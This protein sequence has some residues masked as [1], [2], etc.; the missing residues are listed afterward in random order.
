[1]ADIL[2]TGGRGLVGRRL[3]NALLNKG[4]QVRHVSRSAEK[5]SKT[6]AFQWDIKTGYIDPAS[7]DGIDHIVHLAGAPIVEKKWTKGRVQELI[8]SRAKSARILFQEV[9]KQ[10]V[11]LKGF[12]SASGSNYYGILDSDRIFSEEDEV[13]NDTIAGITEEWERAVRQFET[14]TRTIR[15]RMGM[16]LSKDGGALPKFANTIKMGIGSP[17]G[18]GKQWVPWV[19][20]DDV[21]AL[22]IHSIEDEEFIGAYNAI[23]DEHITNKQL[24]EGIAKAMKRPVWVPKLPAFILRLMLGERADL[25]LKGYRLSNRKLKDAG[26]KFQF[27]TLEQALS[28][29]FN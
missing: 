4:H 11:E 9:Q 14:L 5:N 2:I 20:V 10:G 24:I 22:F 8:A 17:L 19:H 26:F 15:F 18:S 29:E 7:L 6:P 3:T 16:V 13:G 28:R 12:H 21:V 23:A 1:M 27:P 25:V